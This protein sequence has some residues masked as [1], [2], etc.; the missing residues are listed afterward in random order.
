[1]SP[2]G[3]FNLRNAHAGSLMDSKGAWPPRCRLHLADF[4]FD[5]LSGSPGET[6]TDMRR[7][8]EWWDTGWARL[9]PD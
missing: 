6:E 4:G 1:M 9:D 7:R 5:R 8:G 2:P 3:D